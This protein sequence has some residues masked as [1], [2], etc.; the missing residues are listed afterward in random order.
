MRQALELAIG[1]GA[2]GALDAAVGLLRQHPARLVPVYVL[3]ITPMALAMLWVIDAVTAQ[4]R[5]AL[6][7][8]C[9]L[10]TA[11]ALWRWGWLAV[12]Q[13]RAAA[14]LRGNAPATV[15]QRLGPILFSRLVA[16]ALLTW[17]ALLLVPAYWGFFLSGFAGPAM[18]EQREGTGGALR[19]TLRSIT[20]GVGPLGRALAMLAAV[21]FAVGV[22]AIVTQV[23][24]A[25]YV[26]P[27]LTGVAPTQVSLTMSGLAW[28]L[29]TAFG[30]FCVFDLYWHV[31]A[32]TLFYHLAGRRLG[33][34]LQLRLAA[35]EQGAAA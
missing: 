26:L 3:A 12:M 10:L 13:R 30:L 20:T 32:V 28:R 29:A 22:G 1:R 34:D 9:A 19:R 31:A 15:R 5:S 33:T 35:L 11:A 6:A 14:L 27:A 17:G 16:S 25:T 23:V 18:L 7:I 4:D 8:G 2:S 24:A 21:F